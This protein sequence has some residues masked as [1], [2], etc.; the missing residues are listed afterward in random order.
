[1]VWDVGAHVGI[2]AL[3]AAFDSRVAKTYAF[4][5]VPETLSA[6]K[7]N[8]ALNPDRAIETFGEALGNT[9]EERR[10]Y[11]P[12]ANNSGLNR[13]G[14]TAGAPSISVPVTT[15]DDRIAGGLRPPTLMKIDV[16][17]WE[18]E[19]LKGATGALANPAFKAIAFE[20]E[21]DGRGNIIDSE[22]PELLRRH[23][24]QVHRIDRPEPSLRENFIASRS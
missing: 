21:V 11:K 5:P 8:L 22:L 18:L 1:M 15:V 17:G 24:F 20:A 3:K 16:E 10:L 13:L 6:L 14:Q 7:A 9:K 12:A 2:F 4:E 19:V 23:G